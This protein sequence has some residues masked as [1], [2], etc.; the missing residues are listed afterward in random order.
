[1]TR[2]SPNHPREP[3]R[4]KSG[5]RAFSAA[6]SAFASF[7]PR[8]GDLSLAAAARADDVCARPV[9]S[10]RG[11]Y[12]PASTRSRKSSSAARSAGAGRQGRARQQGR[13]ADH[14]SVA[15]RPLFRADAEH[16]A[17]RR[18]L[19]QDHQRRRPQAPQGDRSDLEVPEG[20]GVILRT[21]GASRT[22]AEI[23]R[24]FEYLL[25]LWENVRELTLRRPRRARLRGRQ[26][27]Q[28]LD[29]RPLQQ[30]H[31]RG[32]RRRRRRLPRGQGLHAHAHAE[33]CQERAALPDPQPLFARFGVEA[34][35]DAMFSPQV[36][37]PLG[38]LHRHQPDR[39]AGR[40]ST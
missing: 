22:K 37:L 19:A 28:A 35:L 27:D 38:R 9:R 10:D 6:V 17:R 24:D 25:R 40:R 39:G 29:P 5:S 7:P 14:L 11:E 30:G 23:K 12:R 13:G 33:P 21:A 3:S 20:M 16:R 36:T 2:S 8:P 18:H 34:Q 1:M 32:P 15:R 4:L 26:P 31:R